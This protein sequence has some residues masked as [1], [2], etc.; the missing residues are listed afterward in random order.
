TIPSPRLAVLTICGPTF[1]T[2][3]TWAEPSFA[4]EPATSALASTD[5]SATS[6]PPAVEPAV[7]SEP[8]LHAATASASTSGTSSAS[9]FISASL[10]T[11]ASTG[12]GLRKFP[13]HG[14]LPLLRRRTRPFQ[15]DR[16]TGNREQ[17]RLSELVRG[18]ARR[19][20]R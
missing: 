12:G 3:E 6:P 13:T 17:R 7:L 20:S 1:G 10:V 9:F 14:R 15:R 18:R 5:P 16:R 8:E 11:L 2:A 4:F 19:L